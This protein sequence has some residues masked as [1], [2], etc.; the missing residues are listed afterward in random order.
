MEWNSQLYDNKHDFV[1]EYGKGLLEFVPDNNEQTILDL[2]CG[3]GIMT[4]QLRNLGS[5][6][7]GVDSSKSM[8]SRAKEQFDNIE[9]MLCDALDL[10]FENEFN[11]VFSNAVFHWIGDHDAL[12]SNVRKVLKAD[13]LL[14]CEFGANGNIAI[15]ENAF[16]EVCSSF[17][18]DYTSKFNFPTCESFGKI[19]EGK[20]FVIDKIYDYDRPTPLKD[21][22]QG[23]ANWMKQF[24]ASELVVMPEDIQ[25]AVIKK[26]EEFT[27]DI[28][29]N[30]NEWV[31]DYRRLRAIAHI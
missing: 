7:V 19:L 10:P 30:G 2:G 31:A 12:L 29:W 23:L 21:D 15:V 28:L 27:R 24:F 8:I 22:E 18:Y 4:A 1:A 3:T 13:G 25:V 11:V 14:V 20:G 17:G 6:V 5:K 9:F 16:M 26:V